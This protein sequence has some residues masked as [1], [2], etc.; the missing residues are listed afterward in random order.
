MEPRRNVVHRMALVLF[1]AMNCIAARAQ[2]PDV[3]IEKEFESV[4]QLASPPKDADE[5]HR[6]AAAESFKAAIGRFVTGWSARAADLHRGRFPLGRALLLSGRPAD[7]VPHLE[8]FTREFPQS[9][10]IEDALLSLA[11][12]YLDTERTDQAIAVYDDFLKNRPKSDQ[13]IPALYYLAIAQ[14][15]AGRIDTGLA[16]LEEVVKTGAEHPL[17]ADASLKI[18]ST[19]T[20]SG[21]VTEARARLDELLKAHP[22]APALVA[23]REQLDWLGKPAPE[24][25]GVRTW[26]NGAGRTLAER[27]GRVVVMTFFAS[28]YDSCKAEL[29]LMRDLSTR[30]AGRPVEF[31]GLTTYYRKKT[32]SAD[33]EDKLLREFLDAEKVAFPVAVISD[34]RMLKALSVKGIPHTVVIA[35]D[36]TIAHVKIGS[37]RTDRRSATAL[38]EAVERAL[39]TAK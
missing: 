35:P 1:L 12:G 9:E 19:L 13:R 24:L 29:A 5:D 2:N 34:F 30:F 11:A 22:D 31:L 15:Q 10:D 20:E 37:S 6:R 38:G 18:V 32:R 27:K 23:Q 33:E 21:R 17:A 39:K 14:L 36:G 26:L 28:F 3:E 7:A 4:L 8:V 16:R 25:D